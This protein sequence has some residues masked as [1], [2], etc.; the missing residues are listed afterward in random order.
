M[1]HGWCGYLREKR[2][3]ILLLFV[4]SFSKNCSRKRKWE[5]FE[6]RILEDIYSIE[7]AKRSFKRAI[8]IIKQSKL[9]VKLLCYANSSS[10][11]SRAT[12]RYLH[13]L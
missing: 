8:S 3:R 4:R 11:T 7:H 9:I 2:Y 6:D 12:T 5:R 1:F 13:N 10:P